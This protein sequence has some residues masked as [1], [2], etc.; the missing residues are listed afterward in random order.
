MKLYEEYAD[1][2]EHFEILAFHDKTV[3][4]F[5]ELDEKLE[6]IREKYW[7]GR[8]LP[9]PVLLDATGRTTEA[10][11]IRAYPTNVLLDPQ[12]RVVKGNPEKLLAEKLGAK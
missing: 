12:G 4:T 8:R 3:K 7:E 9:F 2:R 10:Y 11:G 6:P 1:Q 5:D